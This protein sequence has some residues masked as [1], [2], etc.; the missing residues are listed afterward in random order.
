MSIRNEINR[1]KANVSD[2]FAAVLEKGGTV[3]TEGKSD[4]MADAVRTIPVM[5]PNAEGESF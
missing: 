5:P 1:L 4:E 2:T 3:P